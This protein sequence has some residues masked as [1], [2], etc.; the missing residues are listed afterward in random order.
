MMAF[1]AVLEPLRAANAITSRRLYEWTVVSPEGDTVLA[2]NG[3]AIT[4]DFAAANAP[5]VDF[6]VVCSGGDADRLAAKKPLSWIRRNLRLG[7][8]IGSVADGAFYLAR[9]GLLD[10]M[11][12]RFIGKVSL[13]SPRHFRTSS[14]PAA[15]SLS[16]ALGSRRQ[17]A[18]AR[19][20]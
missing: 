10:N 1:S 20:T 15:F 5:V 19:S 9:A 4:P 16:T 18:S 2:S 6:I 13:H 11:P 3:I 7:A 17:A 8:H 12:A 14:S